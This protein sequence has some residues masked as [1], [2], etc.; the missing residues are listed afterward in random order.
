MMSAIDKFDSKDARI[1]ELEEA[2]AIRERQLSL[3]L[4]AMDQGK[5]P[6]IFKVTNLN[7]EFV[8]FV[9]SNYAW[10]T[11]HKPYKLAALPKGKQ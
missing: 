10:S 2:L 8:D 6:S 3:A 11:Y 5:D 7:G 1:K 9:V 4:A